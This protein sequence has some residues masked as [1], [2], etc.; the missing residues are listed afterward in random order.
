MKRR[1]YVFIE[2]AEF[3]KWHDTY[4]Y[5]PRIPTIHGYYNYLFNL[6]IIIYYMHKYTSK[7][8]ILFKKQKFCKWHDTPG[9]MDNV[10]GY[11]YVKSPY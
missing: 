1:F 5:D 2:E 10:F 6:F 11:N 3:Y 8:D 9:S 4:M 7:E